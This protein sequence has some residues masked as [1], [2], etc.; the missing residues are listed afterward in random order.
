MFLI[1]VVKVPCAG[2]VHCA[3][4]LCPLVISNLSIRKGVPGEEGERPRCGKAVRHEGFEKGH[5]RAEGQ[6]G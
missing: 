2:L 4:T 3:L 6:D 1:S 5:H